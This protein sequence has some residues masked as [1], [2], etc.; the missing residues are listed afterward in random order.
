MYCPAWQQGKIILRASGGHLQRQVQEPCEINQARK[1]QERNPALK[2][3]LEPQKKKKKKKK[4]HT[5]LGHCKKV[6]PKC[7]KK[8]LVQ[9]LLGGKVHNHLQQRRPQQEIRTNLQVQTPEQTSQ[10][11][12]EA[13]KWTTAQR[14]KPEESVCLRIALRKGRETDGSGLRALKVRLYIYRYINPSKKFGNLSLIDYFSLL[15]V[16]I[17]ACLIP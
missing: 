11:T 3:Y 14:R 9:S 10:K 6:K 2:V 7:Q 16:I 12:T 13:S 1:I 8:R 17:D 5:N 4:V 15:L